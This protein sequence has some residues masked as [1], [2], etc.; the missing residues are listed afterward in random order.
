MNALKQGVE[1]A[2]I[3]YITGGQQVAVHRA[4]LQLAGAC[5]EG[6]CLARGGQGPF[7]AHQVIL[8]E[9]IWVLRGSRHV[10]CQEFHEV[11]GAFKRGEVRLIFHAMVV[12]GEKEKG[13]SILLSGGRGGS[14]ARVEG[15]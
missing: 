5:R 1:G 13:L 15:N 2:I 6:S 3:I 10:L 7:Q 9:Q 4:C 11:C 12:P 14:L 8:L